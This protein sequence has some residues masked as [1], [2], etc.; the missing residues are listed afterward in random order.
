MM[1]AIIAHLFCFT[2][3]TVSAAS[4]KPT[5]VKKQANILVGQTEKIK[6]KHISQKAKIKYKSSNNSVAAVNKKGK[7]TAKKPGTT[8][9]TITIK[10]NKK[11]ST[12]KYTIKIKKPTLTNSGLMLRVGETSYLYV[13]NG[14]ANETKTDYIWE[15]SDNSIVSVNNG[16]IT[17]KA[18][19]NAIISV[20]VY[21]AG[22]CISILNATISVFPKD[23]EIN[24]N[25]SQDEFAQTGADLIKQTGSPSST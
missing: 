22:R 4:K 8:K 3:L 11:K 1:V 16:A 21:Y 19:G 6:I 7:V 13:D 15:S 2:D 20:K 10:Q 5:L 24:A 23:G 18:E 17:A 9:I 25:L 12:L 14:P